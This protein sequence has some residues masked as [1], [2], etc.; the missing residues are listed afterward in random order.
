[1]SWQE[2]TRQEVAFARHLS[3]LR[4]S[5][6]GRAVMATFRRG[7]G[8]EPGQAIEMYRYLGGFLPHQPG[9]QG[10]AVFIVSSLFASYPDHPWGPGDGRSTNFGASL[11]QLK[12]EDGSGGI[13]RRFVALLNADS[14]GLPVHLRHLI[15]QC[16]PAGVPI[17]WS[18]LLHDIRQWDLSGQ[19]AQTRWAWSFWHVPTQNTGEADDSNQHSDSLGG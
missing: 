6:N 18:Q 16:K 11:T 14:D 10:D 3:Q 19:P 12:R 13:E 4:D 5:G 1:M 9:R 15:A 8:H 7:L 17:D 2:P